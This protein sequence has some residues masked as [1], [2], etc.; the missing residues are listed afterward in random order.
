MLEYL[1]RGDDGE[2][3]LG[4][5]SDAIAQTL[6]PRGCNAVPIE[7][8]GSYRLR[9]DS[10]EVSF[11]DEAGSGWQVAFEGDIDEAKAATI[12]EVIARQLSEFTGRPVA[13]VPL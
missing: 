5:R 3:D 4:I 11:S 2:P 10:T 13:V 7:G 6:T 8:W 9:I 12:V 1:I